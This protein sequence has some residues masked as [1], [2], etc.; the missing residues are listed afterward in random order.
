MN[1]YALELTKHFESCRLETYLCAAGVPTIAYGNTRH[2]DGRKV[3]IGDNITQEQADLYLEEELHR[4]LDSMYEY[5]FVPLNVQ[6]EGALLSFVY[7]LGIGNFRSSTLLEFLN[8][9]DYKRASEQF[10]WWRRANGKIL[11]GLV[12]RRLS[13]TLLFNGE[14][15]FIIEKLPSNWKELYYGE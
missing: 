2:D 4:T 12:R 10:K 8:I 1:K 13:E 3:K 14:D 9:G 15:D 7:N 6:M 11:T 5:I